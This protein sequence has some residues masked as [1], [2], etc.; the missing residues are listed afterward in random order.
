MAKSE[1]EYNL[2]LCSDTNAQ[3]R[4]QWF[5]FCASNVRQGRVVKFNI[6]NM[7]KY[8]YFIKDGMK[9]SYFSEKEHRSIYSSWSTNRIDNLTLSKSTAKISGGRTIRLSDDQE[10]EAQETA[11]N[12]VLSFTHTFKY[13]YD[14]VYFAFVTP[15]PYTRLLKFL[16]Y[17]EPLIQDDSIIYKRERLCSSLLEIPVDA[18]AISSARRGPREK[19]YIVITARMH[20]A[21]TAGSYKVQGIVKFLV[22]SDPV[23]E[24][25]RRNHI[26]LIVPLV[27]PDGVLLG[28]NRCSLAGNDMNRCWGSPDKFQEPVIHKLK[29]K[30]AEIYRT[31]KN[32]ILIYS[33]LHGH[34][35]LCNSFMFACHKGTGTLC[36]WTKARL[37]P[38]I[39]AKRCHMFNYHSCSFKVEPKKANTAR[40]IVWKEFKVVNSFTLE[41]SQYAYDLG[42]EIVR[43]TERDYTM[44]AEFLMIALDE[45]RKLLIELQ[46]EFRTG[47]LKPCQL[48][49][50]TGVP[51]ADLLRR[52]IEEEKAA[53]RKRDKFDK[54]NKSDT[55]ISKPFSNLKFSTNLPSIEKTRAL[56]THGEVG[57]ASKSHSM[58]RT[59]RASWKDY[60]TDAELTE[61]N[62]PPQPVTALE[63]IAEGK[64]ALGGNKGSSGKQPAKRENTL[65]TTA[66]AL[67][68]RDKCVEAVHGKVK[69]REIA[70]EYSLCS[71]EIGSDE[72]A[73]VDGKRGISLRRPEVSSLRGELRNSTL[74]SLLPKDSR[75]T[76][77][78]SDSL[79]SRNLKKTTVSAARSRGSYKTEEATCE[80]PLQMAWLAASIDGRLSIRGIGEQRV[81]SGLFSHCKQYPI[82]SNAAQLRSST[83]QRK[84][85]VSRREKGVKHIR[86]KADR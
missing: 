52:E 86:S 77:R 6:V 24:S 35:R 72:S 2:Y 26:F 58:Q 12:Y 28:N 65:R 83:D 66:A 71:K 60:F 74:H 62:K 42:N 68:G 47:W 13:D 50:L 4:C 48:K 76:E 20:S 44:L 36:S 39:L 32:Q 33:D 15:Y 55:G 80:R 59:M 51:A 19:T 34:S 40:I 5:Y 85:P 22:S 29:S 18:I 81:S 73:L 7:T 63:P 1:N 45:Y 37:L 11:A 43:F 8:P 31:G 25:L 46:N 27:N 21:E 79:N 49:E 14:K 53:S 82:A 41:S 56:F 67:A 9:P 78:P 16:N 69:N 75:T 30:L 17:V 84:N 61:L 54:L 70:P 38:R 57:E 64:D 23:A 10:S 3:N